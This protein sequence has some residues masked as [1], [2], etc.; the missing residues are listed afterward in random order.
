M[1]LHRG[2][3]LSVRID[4]RPRAVPIPAAWA[5][6]VRGRVAMYKRAQAMVAQICQLNLQR[7]LRRKAA[8]EPPP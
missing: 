3:Q 6:D 8:Q 1:H 2:F 7:L 5:E 4:G